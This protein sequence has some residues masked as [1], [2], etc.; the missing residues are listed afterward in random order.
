MAYK[1]YKAGLLVRLAALFLCLTALAFAIPL[2]NTFYIVLAILGILIISSHLYHYMARRF[3]QMDDFFESVKYRD[4]SRW[5]N[6]RTGPEDMR[7]LYKGF[8]EVNRTIKQINKEKE[9]Q[10]LYLQKILEMVD[11]AIIAYEISTGNVLWINE[12]FMELLNVPA[13][14]KMTFLENRKPELYHAIFGTSPIQSGTMD[15][16][17]ENERTKVLVADSIFILGEETFKL[18]ALQNVDATVNETESEAWKKL[19]SVMTHE[20]MNS[21]APISS[22]A[23]TLQDQVG[24]T[25]ENPSTHPLDIEDLDAG[26]ES[27][28][29]RSEGLM[30]FAK[31]YRSLNKVTHLNLGT[32]MV[33]HMFDNIGNLIQPSL[34]KKKVAL[35]F[36]L[37]NKDLQIKIDTYL[38]EQVLINLIL[39]AVEACEGKDNPKITVAAK[40]NNKEKTILKVTDNGSGIP[41]EIMDQIFVP[42]F[43]TKKSG[44][45]IGLSLSKQIM[46]LHKGRIHI[47]SEEGKG[48]AVSLIF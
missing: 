10:H 40:R 17:V 15:I 35:I 42:F 48:T 9:A 18:I 7:Q 4:F 11:T 12:A 16:E 39:N 38:I 14:K 27:I 6:D 37:D 28:K 26:I 44:S 19:L 36:A 24:R 31:T 46:L 23:E 32:V 22:L 29:K 8:N 2:K 21:I 34:E 33:G 1:K 30:M 45:G 41:R 25:K 5:F 43:T 20:I 3:A 13:F 47:N